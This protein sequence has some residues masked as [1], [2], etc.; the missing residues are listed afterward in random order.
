MSCPDS[1]PAGE[2]YD[3]NNELRNQCCVYF[4]SG[5]CSAGEN[6]TLDLL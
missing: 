6:A 2:V 1:L 5:C 4:R 3:G